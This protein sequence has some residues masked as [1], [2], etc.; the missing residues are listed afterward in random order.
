M[1]KI[2]LKDIIDAQKAMYLF[3]KG[4]TYYPRWI[5]I[6]FGILSWLGLIIVCIGLIKIYL[7]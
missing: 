6:C 3:K 2:T 4:Y 1:N 5:E 7:S